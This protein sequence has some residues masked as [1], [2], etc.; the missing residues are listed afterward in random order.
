MAEKSAQNLTAALT[1]S[2]QTTLP[3]FIY[4][5]GIREVGEATALALANHFGDLDGLKQAE[6]EQLEEVA[7]VGPVVARSIHRYLRDADNLDVIGALLDHGI[8]WP[9][10]RQCKRPVFGVR[11][12]C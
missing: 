10:Q 7:D 5:L 3:R 8:N 11:S 1:A 4:A 9:D 6:L 12:G 2:K